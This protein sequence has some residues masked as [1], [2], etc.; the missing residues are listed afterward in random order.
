M[1]DYN[2]TWESH[3]SSLLSVFDSYLTNEKFVDVTLACEGKAI[4][5]HRLVLLASSSYF[6]VMQ[7]NNV[8]SVY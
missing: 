4:H 3:F 1:S 2:L 7:Y 8:H 6:E 5:V